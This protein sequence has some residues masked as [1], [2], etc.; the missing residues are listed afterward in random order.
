LK[1]EWNFVSFPVNIS[2]DKSDIT[3]SC[4]RV[5]Y[6]W[7]DAVTSGIL[8]N[9]VYGWSRSL[10]IY[11]IGGTFS[12]GEGYWVYSYKAC[13]LSITTDTINDDTYISGLQQ[14]WNLIGLP[15][16]TPVNKAD[17]IV[18]HNGMGY[19]WADAVSNGFVLNYIYGWNPTLKNYEMSTVLN[20]GTAYWI[21]GYS[22]CSLKKEMA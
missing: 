18:V 21:Y 1:E 12:P 16:S 9:F 22:S 5:N 10:Q 3:V 11:S 6:S 4:L 19:S 20:P 15:F 14:E 17:L 13:N 2:V 7:E 8:L